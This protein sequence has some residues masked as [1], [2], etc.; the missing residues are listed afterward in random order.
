MKNLFMVHK[1]DMAKLLKIKFFGNVLILRRKYTIVSKTAETIS[2]LS[3][4]NFL[5]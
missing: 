5:K 2:A 3:D 1:V 4:K